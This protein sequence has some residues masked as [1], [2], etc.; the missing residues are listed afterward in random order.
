[1]PKTLSI[2]EI[3]VKLRAAAEKIAMVTVDATKVDY[4]ARMGSDWYARAH[5]D[6]M[7]EMPRPPRVEKNPE[8]E[9]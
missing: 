3:Q 7:F 6:A 2:T 5:G 4:I 1:M 9:I 8:P